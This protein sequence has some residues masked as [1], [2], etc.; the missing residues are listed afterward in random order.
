MDM[1]GIYG[2]PLPWEDTIR[3]GTADAGKSNIPDWC[4][5][6]KPPPSINRFAVACNFMENNVLA[7]R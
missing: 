6:A 4:S 3:E 1:D 2:S 7:R 5:A